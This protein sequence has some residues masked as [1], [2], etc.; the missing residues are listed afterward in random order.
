MPINCHLPTRVFRYLIVLLCALVL[1]GCH[2]PGATIQLS[3]SAATYATLKALKAKEPTAEKV[4]DI[5]VAV[6]LSTAGGQVDW[7]ALQEQVIQQIKAHFQ[8]TEQPVL[9]ALASQITA[10]IRASLPADAPPSKILVYINAG[11]TGVVDGATFYIASIRGPPPQQLT[12]PRADRLPL[13]MQGV[14]LGAG[15]PGT[16]V[17]R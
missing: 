12:P 14:Q 4:I 5:A 2:D 3:A 15:D 17:W 6:K 13:W 11:A 16:E 10:V 8:E 7:M 1:A 9:L